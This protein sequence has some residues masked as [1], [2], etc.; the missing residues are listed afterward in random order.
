MSRNE[1][2][3]AS[4]AVYLNGQAVVSLWG[5]HK[6]AARTSS[7]DENTLANV[8]SVSKGVLATCI[9]LL[10][11]RKQLSYDD[12][13]SRFWPEFAQNGKGKLHSF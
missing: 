7:W 1:E 12:K 2:I 11:A 9:A 10:V 6:D 5:G 13:I 8:F 3:G 4:F